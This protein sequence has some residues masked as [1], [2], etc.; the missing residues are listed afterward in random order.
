MPRVVELFQH[1]GAA[2]KAKSQPSI[3][4]MQVGTFMQIMGDDARTVS[5]ITG[6]KLRM[7]GEVDD[8]YVVA[9]F[10][11]SGLD[12]YIGKLVRAGHSVVIAMQDESK[13]RIITERI[14]IEQ[15]E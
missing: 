2:L 8:P 15:L 5:G 9:G 12:K 10:P 14:K 13:N 4:L 3:L 11:K 6:I 7:A 1:R